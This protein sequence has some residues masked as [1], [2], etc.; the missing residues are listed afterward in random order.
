MTRNASSAVKYADFKILKLLTRLKRSIEDAA[1]DL[2]VL[3]PLVYRCNCSP[4]CLTVPG[5]LS[6]F[7]KPSNDPSSGCRRP[8][9]WLA[10]GHWKGLNK[11]NCSY[12]FWSETVLL[13]CKLKPGNCWVISSSV[14]LI[15][16]SLLFMSEEFV[17]SLLKCTVRKKTTAVFKTSIVKDNVMYI[18]LI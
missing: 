10:I 3:P 1:V 2:L 9:K 4:F 14:K 12:I 16:F 15:S 17:Y 5:L 7:Y 6:D 8:F 13:R 11:W 18:F